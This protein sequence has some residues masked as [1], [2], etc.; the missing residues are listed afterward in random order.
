MIEAM[1]LPIQETRTP[2][3]GPKRAP[4]RITIG[5]VGMGVADS[6][7][8]RRMERSGPRTPVEGINFSIDLMSFLKTIINAMGRPKVSMAIAMLRILFRSFL[9]I[10][11]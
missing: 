11:K 10:N 1:L 5:S 7:P 6:K 2:I 3:H 9:F 8:I 4:L